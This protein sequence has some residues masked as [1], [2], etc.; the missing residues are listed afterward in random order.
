M[1]RQGLV[2]K[3]PQKKSNH[4]ET[5]AITVT[6]TVQFRFNRATTA[7]TIVIA[8]NTSS[9]R[10]QS[11]TFL[12]LCSTD[13]DTDTYLIP[14]TELFYSFGLSISLGPYATPRPV[15]FK[16]EPKCARRSTPTRSNYPSKLA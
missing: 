4:K 2:K 1:T 8:S 15:L 5:T 7:Y 9:E 11:P 16:Y 10:I 12:P 3:G 6:Y 14:I 13:T